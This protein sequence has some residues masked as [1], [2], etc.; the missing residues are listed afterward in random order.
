MII[1]IKT[2]LYVLTEILLLFLILLLFDIFDNG[3][4]HI[5]FIK[6]R[7]KKIM[8]FTFLLFTCVLVIEIFREFI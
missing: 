2:I 4:Y 8:L 5:F 3:K 7:L 6:S 1:E